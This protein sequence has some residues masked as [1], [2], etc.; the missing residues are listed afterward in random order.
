MAVTLYPCA[1]SFL[2]SSRRFLFTIDPLFHY[3][4]SFSLTLSSLTF[5]LMKKTYRV[6]KWR[7]IKKLPSRFHRGYFIC[8]TADEINEGKGRF[9]EMTE[10]S[11]I[12]PLYLC[13]SSPARQNRLRRQKVQQVVQR[14]YQ[15]EY[16][17]PYG[18][19]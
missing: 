19:V 11:E 2:I 8:M 12:T 7:P 10:R 14:L 1:A 4:S 6:K 13:F 16:L 17:H 3:L 18:A 5:K 15:A 9:R